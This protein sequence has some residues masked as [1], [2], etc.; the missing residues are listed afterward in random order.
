MQPPKATHI[1]VTFILLPLST[2]PTVVGSFELDY[3]NIYVVLCCV[4]LFM[5]HGGLSF[6]TTSNN[7]RMLF[8]VSKSVG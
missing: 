8:A 1:S 2:L 4:L 7:T 3:G 6:D 5:L